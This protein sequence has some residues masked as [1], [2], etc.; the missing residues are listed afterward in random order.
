M[1]RRWLLAAAIALLT[2]LASF[3]ADITGK[4]VGE[5]GG[6]QFTMT[7]NFKQDGAKLT[8]TSD[9]PG[10]E[11]LQIQAGKVEGNKISFN[12]S[13]DGEMKIGFEGTINGDEITLTLK[14]DGG[15]GGP[16]GP[17][18]PGPIKLK[19]AK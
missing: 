1:T 4:W 19:R 3:A 17:D 8:G 9:G 15:P 11:P 7:F 16:G 5:M 18:G 6:G 12:M 2:P 13:P 10:G 14:M